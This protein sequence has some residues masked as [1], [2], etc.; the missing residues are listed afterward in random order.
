MRVEK[1]SDLLLTASA[2]SRLCLSF[3]LQHLAELFTVKTAECIVW[4]QNLQRFSYISH[5]YRRK[6]VAVWACKAFK[7]RN[8]ALMQI[9][10][11]IHIVFYRAGLVVIISYN[12][13]PQSKINYRMLADPS[14]LQIED[15]FVHKR[16]V[17]VQRHIDQTCTA[18][19]SGGPGAG[20][21]VFA[22]LKS[23][24]I[25]MRVA[26]NNAW[27]YIVSLCIND[28]FRL[29]LC[30]FCKKGRVYSVF[31]RD[32]SFVNPVRGY[33]FPVFYN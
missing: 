28:L 22:V 8:A 25:E 4:F 24:F 32:I 14:H 30:S 11:V 2:L 15:F 10:K 9:H 19:H 18:C 29:C 7:R 33:K 27:E 20:L 26:V 23:R 17:I 21:E 5:I 3:A 6:E 16:R 1:I 12:A 13:S 31:H